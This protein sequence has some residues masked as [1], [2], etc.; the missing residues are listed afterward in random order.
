MIAIIA[1]N[2]KAF[3]RA[4]KRLNGKPCTHI[5]TPFDLWG[6]S[7]TDVILVTAPMTEEENRHQAQLYEATKRRIIQEL[8]KKP[9]SAKVHNT[10]LDLGFVNNGSYY[11]KNGYPIKVDENTTLKELFEQL[12]EY[13][14]TT[15]VWEIKTILQL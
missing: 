11:K 2:E 4:K 6:Q 10:L 7:F 15:K 5:K 9:K 1:E 13:G 8:P 12:I 3:E 14:E